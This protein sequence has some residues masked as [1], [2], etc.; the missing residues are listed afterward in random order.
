[1]FEARILRSNFS[2]FKLD[3]KQKGVGND[4]TSLGAAILQKLR[5]DARLGCGELPIRL[6]CL[7]T[8]ELNLFSSIW[9]DESAT[10]RASVTCSAG[11]C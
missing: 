6:H 8:E 3:G 5:L 11:V 9:L 10:W 4:V 2:E 1:M 7:T